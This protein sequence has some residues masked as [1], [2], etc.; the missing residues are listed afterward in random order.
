MKKNNKLEL[1]KIRNNIDIIDNK[2]L[3]LLNQRASFA[4]KTTKFKP[5]NI[6][7]PKREKEVLNNLSRIKQTTYPTNRLSKYMGK[8]FQL[9]GRFK[10]QSRFHI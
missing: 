9:V 3:K 8:Y 5:N 4:K 7:D 6:Y 10:P 1:V 2:I